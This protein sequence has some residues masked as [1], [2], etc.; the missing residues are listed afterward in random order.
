MRETDA[1]LG[2]EMSGHICFKERWYGFDDGVYAAARLLEV[3]GSQPE[4][5]AE[6]LSEFPDGVSTPEI[7]I[8]VPE[9]HKFDIVRQIIDRA[10]FE[11]AAI[12]T[13]DG[14]RVDFADSWG[15]VRASNTSPCLTLRFE[16]DNDDSLLNIQTLFRDKLSS[17]NESLTF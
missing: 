10:D 9:F 4:G 11:D 15:L 14:L 3:V 6:L 2:G 5:L 17:V 13:I 8:D 1:I 12:T 16:A 7:T